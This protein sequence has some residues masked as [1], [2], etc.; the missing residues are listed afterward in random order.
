MRSIFSFRILL[1]MYRKRLIVNVDESSFGRWVQ[2]NYSWLPKGI[3]SPIVNARWRGRANLIFGLWSNGRWM[4]VIQNENGTAK[5]FKLFMIFL[6]K[7]IHS[8]YKSS[9]QP[10]W[11]ILDNSA[12]HFTESVRKLA[13]TIG[14]E[15]N[16]IPSYSPNLAPVEMVF[17]VAKRKIW[18]MKSKE[19][20][21]FSYPSGKKALVDVL[22]T[23]NTDVWNGM[24]LNFILEANKS[25]I[26]ML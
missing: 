12:I 5:N 24:W 23:L 9:V 22:K 21:D 13:K 6:K 16:S 17:G 11:V 14:I 20:I 2:T 19:I 25:I 3:T 26:A 7:Y 4:A 8:W 1:N 10:Y 15:H 18:C